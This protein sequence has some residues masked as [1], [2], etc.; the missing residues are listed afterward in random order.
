LTKIYDPFL[1][2]SFRG[3]TTI[4]KSP[5]LLTENFYGLKKNR[6]ITYLAKKENKLKFGFLTDGEIWNGRIYHYLG[7]R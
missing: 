1:N 4:S 5:W 6:K 2:G 3:K 7:N